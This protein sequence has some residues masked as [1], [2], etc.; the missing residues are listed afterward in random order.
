MAKSTKWVKIEVCKE[1]LVNTK[2]EGVRFG[3]TNCNQGPVKDGII[4]SIIRRQK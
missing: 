2:C 1:C 4:D 3:S